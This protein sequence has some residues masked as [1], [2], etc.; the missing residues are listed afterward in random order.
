ML[1]S[2]LTSLDGVFIYDDAAS[3]I[4]LGQFTSLTDGGLSLDGG[5]YDL[6]KLKDIDGSSLQV[7]GGGSLELSAVTSYTSGAVARI[8]AA[9]PSR[10]DSPILTPPPTFRWAR[11]VCRT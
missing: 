10:P 3:S 7:Q 8:M 6:P 5:S 1:D 9:T 11:S 4:S 2:N